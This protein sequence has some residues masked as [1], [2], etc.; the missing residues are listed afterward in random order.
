MQALDASVTEVPRED[1]TAI[2]VEPL[3]I[4][5][6]YL[7]CIYIYTIYIYIYII[8]IYSIYI[9]RERERANIYIYIYYIDIIYIPYIPYIYICI[10]NIFVFTLFYHTCGFITVIW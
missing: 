9:Y 5:T 2:S 8:C 10:L 4:G 1:E 6:V 3:V 7:L